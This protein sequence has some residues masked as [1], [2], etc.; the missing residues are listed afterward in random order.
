VRRQGETDI[1]RRLGGGENKGVA[2]PVEIGQRTLLGVHP[3][4]GKLFGR[5]SLLYRGRL[6]TGHAHGPCE[7]GR[8][9]NTNKH[10]IL[11]HPFNRLL[12]N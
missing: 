2:V 1:G 6:N 4:G 10:G 3:F 12:S 7:N 8:R 5:R 11:P 9:H